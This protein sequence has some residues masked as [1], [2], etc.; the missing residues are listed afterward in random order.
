MLILIKH[1]GTELLGKRYR[2]AKANEHQRV[3]ENL[4]VEKYA[5][6]V[7]LLSTIGLR[8]NCLETAWEPKCDQLSHQC[9]HRHGQT[10]GDQVRLVLHIAKDNRIDEQIWLVEGKSQDDRAREPCKLARNLQ[11]VLLF[12]RLIIVT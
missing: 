5:A 6:H 7:V 4:P 3:D 12:L 11:I 2:D 8:D 9:N 10:I 1:C